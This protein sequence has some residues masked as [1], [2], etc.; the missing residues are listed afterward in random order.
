MVGDIKL[1]NSTGTIISLG[2]RE[3]DYVLESVNWDVAKVSTDTIYY[4]P[5]EDSERVLNH[6]WQPR[7]VS[8]VGWVIGKD[9]AD[10][11]GKCRNLESFV[12]L[13]DAVKILYNGY[14]LTFYP[15]K[16]VKFANTE[17]EN[18]E[19]LCKFQIEG[20]CIDP[21]WCDGMEID[22]SSVMPSQRH[23]LPKFN[24]PLILNRNIPSAIFGDRHWR[25]SRLIHHNNGMGPRSIVLRL[26]T[27]D[28]I[29]HLTIELK[30]ES[31]IQWFTLLREYR[32]NTEIVIDT[33]EGFHSVLVNGTNRTENVAP[34]S[35]W[36]QL[37]PGTNILTF[38]YYGAGNL[39]IDIKP[40][41]LFEVQT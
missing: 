8:I 14:H 7:S 13:Q 15:I 6:G 5:T 29:R 40:I 26:Q 19:V 24:F 37:Q 33:W 28:I 4:F 36:L 38:C 18:N 39:I 11:E 35:Q 41:D 9:E 20:I 12:R 34:G 10:I 2:T 1:Q 31:G 22:S 3:N 25:T 27:T 23:T 17:R 21:I 30:H 16:K 32:E